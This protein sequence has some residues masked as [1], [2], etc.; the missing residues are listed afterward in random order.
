M[1]TDLCLVIVEHLT[2]ILSHLLCHW[3]LKIIL[4]GHKMQYFSFNR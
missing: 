4:Q 3:V 2:I 1:V